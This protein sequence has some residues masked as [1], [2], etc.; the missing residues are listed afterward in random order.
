VVHDDLSG[1]ALPE[2]QFRITQQVVDVEIELDGNL[3]EFLGAHL[4]GEV[5]HEPHLAGGHET[6]QI[7]HPRI[8]DTLEEAAGHGVVVAGV[9]PVLAIADE[10]DGALARILR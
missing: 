8:D 9:G 2:V 5:V 3:L 1:R 7:V 6:A 10:G 4:P